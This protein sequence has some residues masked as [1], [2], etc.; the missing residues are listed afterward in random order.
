[1]SDFRFVPLG[2]VLL[3]ALTT[4]CLTPSA[5]SVQANFPS[6]IALAHPSAD[7]IPLGEARLRVI[8][9]G[10]WIHVATQGYDGTVYPSNGLIVRDGDG[11]LLVDTAWGG[12]NTAALLATI[13]A[14]IGLPVRRSISTHFHDDRVA[15][16]EILAADGVTTLEDWDTHNSTIR[17]F[18]G[19]LAKSVGLSNF[20]SARAAGGDLPVLS[21][22]REGNFG[23]W[24]VPEP[25][26]VRP[27]II[28]SAAVRST[29]VRKGDWR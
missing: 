28:M 12:A 13:K 8:R 1:M 9:D 29:G 26:P 2:L 5:R 21:A 24:D 15:G 7:E 16:V 10:V 25:K 19:L 6:D 17:Q 14:E 27:E 4:G 22:W 18:F 3:A 23:I 11:L 20:E